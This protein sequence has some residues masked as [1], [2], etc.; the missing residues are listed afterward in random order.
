M[1]RP[2]AGGPRGDAASAWVAAGARRPAAAAGPS[3]GA[4]TKRRRRSSRRARPHIWRFSMVRRWRGPATGPLDQGRGPPAVTASEA[5][6]SPVAQRC[7]AC[8]VLGVARGRQGARAAGGR[9]RPRCAKSWARSIAAATAVCWART[10]ARCGVSAAVRL[11][12]RRSTSHVVRRGGSGGHAGAATPGHV[13]RR[14]WRLGARPGAWRRRLAEAATRRALPVSPWGGSAR[15]RGSAVRQPACQRA[16]RE[17]WEGGRRRRPDGLRW[18]GTGPGGRR[19]DRS[20][21]GRL[22]PAWAAMA[23][24]VPPARCTV[25]PS[26]ESAGR[27]R[28]GRPAA[29][30]VGAWLGVA[31]APRPAPRPTPRAAGARPHGRPPGPGAAWC[32]PAPGLPRGAAGAGNGRRPGGPWG[33]LA[34]RPPP[35]RGSGHA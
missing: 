2:A 1:P 9:W 12:A 3:R 22:R 10:W 26:A 32:S 20:L 19:R 11:A 6:W 21:V 30:R 33:R 15:T 4:P 25:H 34:G 18:C 27:P 35:R 8:C 7:T 5:S 31:P 28:A 16:R 29:G 13:G 24:T 17:A 14:P 23:E